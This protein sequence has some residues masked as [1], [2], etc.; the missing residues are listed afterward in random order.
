MAKK[1]SI[2]S[3]TSKG[4]E[5][6]Y[7][8]PTMLA[9]ESQQMV[10]TLKPKDISPVVERIKEGYAVIQVTEHRVVEVPAAGEDEDR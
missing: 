9:P 5:L 7:L 3:S 1:S 6:G 2:D 8:V 10:T 4:G